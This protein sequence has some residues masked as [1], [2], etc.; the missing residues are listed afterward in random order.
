MVL[1]PLRKPSPRLNQTFALRPWVFRWAFGDYPSFVK[2]ARIGDILM[3]GLPC[4]FSGELV[5]ELSRYASNKGL[6][7]I[8]TS[9][10]GA[11]AGYVTDDRHFDKDQYE[12][13]TMSWFGPYN[14]AYFQ[15]VVKD[16]IDKFAI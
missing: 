3:V 5:A 15:E 13:I 10:N 14:G 16:V 6:R 4:D 2:A 7:L 1:L 8:I 9:F 11:Y 12:T